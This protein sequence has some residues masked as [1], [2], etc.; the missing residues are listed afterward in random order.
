M[1]QPCDLFCGPFPD[2][3]H[4]PMSVLYSKGKSS[5]SHPDPGRDR[6]RTQLPRL[7]GAD[8]EAPG[9]L[10]VSSPTLAFCDS[11]RP[12]ALQVVRCSVVPPW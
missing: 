11:L 2:T 10:A 7:S 1:M 6:L 9:S 4:C 8:R 5:V 12:G 3:A